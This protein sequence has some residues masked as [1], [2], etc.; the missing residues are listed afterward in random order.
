M[1]SK[2]LSRKF[3]ISMLVF[4]AATGLVIG[5]YIDGSHWM[6]VVTADVVV[7][8]GANAVEKRG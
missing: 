1:K 8:G 4:L 7:Y 6:T 3:I 5:G 2:Y